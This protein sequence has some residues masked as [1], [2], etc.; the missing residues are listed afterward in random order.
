MQIRGVD[1]V[2]FLVSD[3]A[4]AVAFYR[5]VLGL[6]CEVESAEGQ[7]AEFDC[8]NVTLSLKGSGLAAGAK[9]G[10]RLALAVDDVAK[11]HEE[12]LRRGVRMEGPPVDFGVCRALQVLDPDGNVVILHQR[13]DGTCG[14]NPLS[15]PQAP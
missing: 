9:G 7:W 3:L 10:G 4:R 6:R 5:D 11:A 13:A 14:H 1:L 15:R 2:M 8:G 12:L